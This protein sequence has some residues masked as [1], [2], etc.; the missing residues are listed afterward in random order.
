[1]AR[2]NALLAITVMLAGAMLYIPLAGDHK[3]SAVLLKELRSTLKAKDKP[4]KKK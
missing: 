2:G 4:P 3:N 1:M